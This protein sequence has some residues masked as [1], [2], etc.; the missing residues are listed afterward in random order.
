MQPKTRGVVSGIVLIKTTKQV[1]D[2]GV[3]RK[4]FKKPENGAAPELHP[5][6]G[7]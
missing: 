5:E 7:Q 3:G 4:G 2:P 6:D 1:V